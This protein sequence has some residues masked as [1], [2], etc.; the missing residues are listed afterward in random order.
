VVLAQNRLNVY[1]SN[2]LG[3]TPGAHRWRSEIRRLWVTIASTV[4]EKG[5]SHHNQSSGC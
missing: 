5:L 1:I 4:S 3:V 2:D